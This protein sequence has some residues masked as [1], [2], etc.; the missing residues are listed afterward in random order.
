MTP[1]SLIGT[2][3][4]A[5]LTITFARRVVLVPL[6]RRAIVARLAGPP[7]ASNDRTPLEAS[8]PAAFLDHVAREI[9][10]GASASAAFVV[11]S[12]RSPAEAWWT[13]DV[14]TRCRRGVALSDAIVEHASATWPLPVRDAARTL[15]IA[16]RG[17][18]GTADALTRGANLIR[19][20]A[21][22]DGERGT[23]SAHARASTTMLTTIPVALFALCVTLSPAARSAMLG[24][25]LGL[26]SCGLGALGNVAGRRWMRRL[27]DGTRA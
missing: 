13:A 15:A 3:A 25:P 17:G 6:E 14:A 2:A 7:V 20:A 1:L 27:V 18:S 10:L 19:E 23:A 22:L 9:R 16:A 4:A 21:A 5:A 12:E 11:V 8:D 26:A 24:S